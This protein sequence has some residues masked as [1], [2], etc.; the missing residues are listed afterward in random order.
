MTT[1]N[2]HEAKT[3]LSRL[4]LCP[5]SLPRVAKLKS[6]IELSR[7]LARLSVV[8]TVFSA[9]SSPVVPRPSASS[10]H[11]AEKEDI[12]KYRW[13]QEVDI[14]ASVFRYQF[15]HNQTGVSPLRFDYLF[16]SLGRNE[17]FEQD[18]PS[19]LLAQFAGHIPPVEPASESKIAKDYT[20]VSHIHKGGK[21]II[22][23]LER[24]RWIDHDTVRVDGGYYRA[25]R[26]AS[27]NT[28]QAERRDG[29]WV[30]VSDTLHGVS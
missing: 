19:E 13:S 7:L 15:E 6:V 26:S 2:I 21:G 28:Y 30:V 14:L 5:C 22:F 25:S 20:G 10:D 23:R 11:P 8:L 18:P 4:R 16:L 9:C 27:E 1:V 12:L 29:K 3:H 17:L 24:I